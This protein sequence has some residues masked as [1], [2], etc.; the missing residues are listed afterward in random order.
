M[1]NTY[2][3]NEIVEIGVQIEINGRD[4]YNVLVERSKNKDAKT[5]FE[6]LRNEEEKHIAKF[7][8][9]LNSAH[10]YEPKEAYPEEYFA[11][12]NSLASEQ[13]FTKKDKG[14]EVAKS[15]KDEKEA[16]DLGIKAEEDSIAFYK[17]MKK[18]V[19]EDNKKIID[20]VIGEETDHLRRLTELKGIL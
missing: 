16:V 10:K 18:I 9:I 15:I 13:V 20:V 5:I 14:K 7:R 11:Y 4:F 19:P 2:T 12:M 6:H 17:G 1:A 8:E 3:A